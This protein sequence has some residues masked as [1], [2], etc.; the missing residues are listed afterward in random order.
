[1][2]TNPL[3][4]RQMRSSALKT[5]MFAAALAIALGACAAGSAHDRPAAPAE[6]VPATVSLPTGV[7][8]EY[9]ER[10]DPRGIPV[11]LLHG[12]TDSWRSWDL[13][14]PHLPSSLRVFALTQR[15]HGG[16]D[17]P[18]AGYRPAEFAADV[19]AFLD[20]MGIDSAVVVGHSMG[21]IVA[22]RFAID[23]PTRTRGLVLVSTFAPV[24]NH[25]MFRDFYENAVA[26]LT[27][28]I[29]SSFV[30]E[31]QVSTMARPVPAAFVEQAIGETRLVPA[32]VW[33]AIM[34]GL[35]EEDQSAGRQAIR[36][37]TL[38]LYGDRDAYSDRAEQDLLAAIPG[39]TLVMYEGTGHAIPWEEPARFASDLAGFVR[40]I[41]GGAN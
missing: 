9:T 29:D 10:G 13:A 19:A 8:L 30:R 33:K 18:E 17:R 22:Q 23:Y 31:F 25:P 26:G 15:G 7:R 27:D 16:S 28:P 3:W 32:R 12:F 11:I 36:A 2:V 35:L 21:G 14:S 20:V 6:P 39:A 1:M 41:G 40:R 38:I 4:I 34:E 5:P 37:P 24:R